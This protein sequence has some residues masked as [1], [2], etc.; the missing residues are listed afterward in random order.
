MGS[1]IFIR[2]SHV[3][4]AHSLLSINIEAEA[5]AP[6]TMKYIWWLWWI[7]VTIIF[8]HTLCRVKSYGQ[9]LEALNYCLQGSSQAFRADMLELFIIT[10]FAPRQ[11]LTSQ[12]QQRDQIEYRHHRAS[13]S[14]AASFPGVVPSTR[15]VASPMHEGW[16]AAVHS[17]RLKRWS[18]TG[19]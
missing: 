14:K 5:L 9:I 4:C 7:Q 8:T 12:T 1:W 19:S 16:T 17:S 11:G 13:A 10:L 15:F 18:R 2:A 6:Q 3:Q